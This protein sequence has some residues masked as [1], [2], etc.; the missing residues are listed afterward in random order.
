MRPAY[1]ILLVLLAALG[2]T[3][4]LAA[5]PRSSEPDPTAEAVA[6]TKRKLDL[7]L[8]LPHQATKEDEGESWRLK[9]P[10]EAFWIAAAGFGV[11]LAYLL[12][13]I[14]PGWRRDDQG[15]GMTGFGDAPTGQTA[16]ASLAMADALAEQDR[17]VEAMHI[18][19]LHCLDEMKRRLKVDIAD[20]LTSREIVRR[21]RLP[22]QAAIA[23]KGI[24]IR[25][26]SSYFGDYPATRPD[27]DSCRGRYEELVSILSGVPRT[28]AAGTAG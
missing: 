7:Q 15:W 22:E 21:A 24:V 5:D 17:F 12:I 14:V 10:K 1:L 28:A 9:I 3:P 6:N 23:L 4:V 18:L 27:Y 8:T 19:L 26:E 11:V 13:G 2:A 20:S 16:G 25:V